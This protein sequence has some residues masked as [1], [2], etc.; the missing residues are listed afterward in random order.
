VAS[1]H[2]WNYYVSERVVWSVVTAKTREVL[3][4]ILKITRKYPLKISKRTIHTWLYRW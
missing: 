4:S 1:L 3:Q 2:C